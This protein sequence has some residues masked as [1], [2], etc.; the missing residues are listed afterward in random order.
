MRAKP[1]GFELQFT[2]PIDVAT[3]TS[4]DSYQLSTYTYI[5]QSSYGSPEVDH[6]SPTIRDIKAVDATTVRLYIEGLQIGHVHELH[7]DGVRAEKTNFPVLPSS[8]L[9]HAEYLP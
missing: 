7:V 2:Q 8:R 6:T 1:D 9:L 5:Y 4:I 3:A